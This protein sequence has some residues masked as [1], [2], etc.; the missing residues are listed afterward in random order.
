MHRAMAANLPK[1]FYDLVRRCANDTSIVEEFDNRRRTNIVA[2][3]HAHGAGSMDA[4]S[5]DAAQFIK[6][7]YINIWL[8]LPRNQ[9]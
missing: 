7:V 3:H 6:F 8:K 9:D 2:E 5:S 1:E 4:E